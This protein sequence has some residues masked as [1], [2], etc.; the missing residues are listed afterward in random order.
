MAIWSLATDTNFTVFS[1]VE[2][3]D[4]IYI[5]NLVKNYFEESKTVLEKWHPLFMIRGE[6]RKHPDFFEVED[7]DLIA[8]SQKAADSLRSFLNN[9]MELL[10]IETDAGRYY[11]LNVLNFVDCLNKEESVY[12][13]TQ[14]GKIVN[15]S[16]L[17]FDSEKLKDHAI[18]KIP[19]LPYHTFITDRIQEECEEQFLRGLLFD[20]ETNLVWYAE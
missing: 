9:Q 12:T 7:T 15:Y 20:T 11:V 3:A 10:P 4:R 5:H 18:F 19:E 8:I 2:E 16:M 17:E 1:F 14:N 13:A 6:P